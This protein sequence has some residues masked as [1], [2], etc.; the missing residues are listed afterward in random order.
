[1]NLA[2]CQQVLERQ[3]GSAASIFL[4]IG[5]SLIVN[6]DY[7]YKVSVTRQQLVMA[8]MALNEAFVLS[9]SREALKQL[10]AYMEKNG[11]E[12]LDDEE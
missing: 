11:K 3:L 2:H 7:I 6:R 9:A 10:K 5:K 4:R 1:M 12:V 8:D